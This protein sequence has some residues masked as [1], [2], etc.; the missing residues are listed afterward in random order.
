MGTNLTLVSLFSGGGGLD[1]GFEKAG[2]EVMVCVDID[3]ESCKT[4]RYNRPN[5]EVF[6][7]D[8]REFVP[9]VSADIVIGGPPCQGFSTA[10][11]GNPDDPRN[12]LWQEYFRVVEAIRP[13]AIVLENVSGLKNSKNSEHLGGIQ[14]RLTDLGYTFAMGVLNAAD[15]GVPQVRRRLIVIGLLDGTP[16]LPEPTVAEHVTVWEAIEDLECKVEPDLNHIPNSHAAHVVARWRKLEP[17]Q[18][19]PNYGRARLDAT[20]PSTTIRAGGGKGPRGDHLAGFHPPIHPTLPRQLT[21]REAARLQSF[22]DDW[23]FR[24]SKT[25]QGRQVGNAVPVKLA[26]AIANHVVNLLDDK[27]N[28][29][30]LDTRKV[31]VKAKKAACSRRASAG[32]VLERA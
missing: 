9:R 27:R 10:G 29:V 16:S 12:F 17:G 13:K 15:F 18:A 26:E 7:G 22:D 24:G 23:I 30:D 25:A 4:L 1:L 32:R 19:D 5:W 20:K 11:K 6:E 31:K 8:V 2:V 3:P 14:A 21:V 28:V